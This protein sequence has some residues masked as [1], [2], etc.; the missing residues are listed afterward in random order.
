MTVA[1]T[2]ASGAIAHIAAAA[3]VSLVGSAFAG[4][5][6][7]T[8]VGLGGRAAL[9]AFTR[10]VIGNAVMA[11]VF[12]A[13]HQGL[14]MAADM[15]GA[16]RFYTWDEFIV[17]SVYA[18]G[19]FGVLRGAMAGFGQAAR[20]AM[21]GAT[22]TTRMGAAALWTGA[23]TTETLALTGYGLA[24]QSLENYIHDQ[25]VSGVWT[26]TNI[27]HQL[28]HNSLFL[29]GLR[30]GNM[31]AR[32]VTSA[33]TNALM[34][35]SIR[36]LRRANVSRVDEIGA[37][38]R[39]L[40][41]ETTRTGR[42]NQDQANRFHRLNTE[43]LRLESEL[44]EAD[45]RLVSMGLVSEA[46]YNA[47]RLRYNQLNDYVVANRIAHL[48]GIR[49][50]RQLN[51]D[52]YL[53]FTRLCSQQMDIAT[54]Q[55]S[56]L[57]EA[58]AS[59]EVIAE[60]QA[61]QEEIFSNRF[62]QAENGLR[63]SIMRRAN[64]IMDMEQN[65]YLVENETGELVLS[66]RS[67]QEVELQQLRREVAQLRE[68]LNQAI[69]QG[70][71]TRTEYEQAERSLGQL[72]G[73]VEAV[74]RGDITGQA[75]SRWAG[76]VEFLRNMAL[77]PA[78]LFVGVG[79]AGPLGPS[80]PNQPTDQQ[81]SSNAEPP[82]SPPWMQPP[83]P[84]PSIGER[85]RLGAE[86]LW[87]QMPGERAPGAGNRAGIAIGGLGALLLGGLGISGLI[88]WFSQDDDEEE[89]PAPEPSIPQ[90]QPP[91]PEP[92][93]QPE[94]EPEPEPAQQGPNSDL[95]PALRRLLNG[96]DQPASQPAPRTVSPAEPEPA[97]S[98]ASET[99]PPS[100]SD[101]EPN[102]DLPPALQRLLNRAR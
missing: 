14:S 65:N 37:E 33:A 100:A 57:R 69:E 11:P 63:L 53:E 20:L 9:G 18:F 98:S 85:I 40:R 52:E 13:S 10:F 71:M 27:A 77:A 101:I 61:R 16:D 35:R 92:E 93:P 73:R 17:H 36:N 24:E 80:R 54:Q 21:G 91:A 97:P 30:G 58:G 48:H 42:L 25:P 34:P 75:S 38:L 3:A 64:R 12:V 82:A 4:T 28:G 76:F 29:I 59:R 1:I 51:V 47:S 7:S 32:P 70:A 96:Q 83:E 55:V 43:R 60:A 81:T 68:L 26:G 102:S 41:A 45:R 62:R 49:Q 79:G 50:S 15:P 6:T 46:Q 86:N 87:A 74:L 19:M 88:V 89:A 8:A 2:V 66:Q 22:T 99:E 90:P 67:R 94:P 95:P 5:A 78:G 84:A 39:A 23:F 44:L 72:L 56:L 31:L